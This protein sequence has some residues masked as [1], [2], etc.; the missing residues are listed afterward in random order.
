[1][2]FLDEEAEF[3]QPYPEPRVSATALSR[4][5]YEST[6]RLGARCEK[7]HVGFWNKIMCVMVGE[8]SLEK[9]NF[10]L[11]HRKHVSALDLCA[12]AKTYN[13]RHMIGERSVP[14]S[15]DSDPRTSKAKHSLQP[16]KGT[17][18]RVLLLPG[19]CC[20]SLKISGVFSWRSC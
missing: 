1:M 3:V 20:C 5:L 19:H 13:S 4:I 8:S 9:V 10:M 17:A 18:D 7:S 14:E 16:R 12:L 6:I 2:P 15:I 11:Q